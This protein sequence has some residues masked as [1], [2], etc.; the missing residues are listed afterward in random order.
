M[1]PTDE[2][3]MSHP[4]RREWQAQKNAELSASAMGINSASVAGGATGMYSNKETARREWGARLGE[5]ANGIHPGLGARL[6]ASESIVQAFDDAL[7]RVTDAIGSLESKLEPLN[8]YA[9]PTTAMNEL[10]KMAETPSDYSSNLFRS[11]EDRISGLHS[12]AGRIERIKA[13]TEL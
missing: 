4:H 3:P 8:V 13:R 1:Y 6:P 9:G 7:K 12:L 10:E 11:L 2:P 5:V